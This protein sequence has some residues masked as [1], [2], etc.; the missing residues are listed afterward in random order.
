MQINNYNNSPVIFKQIKLTKA[1]EKLAIKYLTSISSPALNTIHEQAK[2]NL[3]EI[4]NKHF[5]IE[6]SKYSKSYL[7]KNDFLQ[8]AYLHFF[9]LIKQIQEKTLSPI[10]FLTEINKILKPSKDDRI[11][12]EKSLDSC[13]T[14]Y[15]KTKLVDT[16]QTEDLPIYASEK[17]PKEKA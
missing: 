4:F 11:G 10:N 5:Q 16:L 9:E 17:S 6:L 2:T 13:L 14:K 12:F 1:E 8:N 7:Y 15:S 3:F